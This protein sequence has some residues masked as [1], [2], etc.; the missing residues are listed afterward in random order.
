M[1][2]PNP[3]PILTSDKLTDDT[4]NKARL[5][6]SSAQSRAK[7]WNFTKLL[8]PASCYDE[9]SSTTWDADTTTV[10]RIG[11]LKTT[12]KKQVVSADNRDEAARKKEAIERTLAGEVI[13]TPSSIQQQLDSE[14]IKLSATLDAID[15][16]TGEIQRE[17]MKLAIEYSKKMRPKHDALMKTF[18]QKQLEALS[19]WSEL[20][21]LKSHLIDNG[22]LHGLCLNLPAA[23]LGAPNDPYSDMADFFRSAK[24]DG[25][26]SAVPKEMRL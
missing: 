20:F 1:T 9:T 15:F 6:A 3:D 5:L 13:V 2:K 14:Q 18:C 22:G 23:F 10:A 4:Q 7:I 26:I 11:L 8:S 25:H 24:N 16:L 12:M 21:N 19:V 17:K